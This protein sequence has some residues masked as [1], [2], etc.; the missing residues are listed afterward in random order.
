[1]QARHLTASLLLTAL[2]LAAQPEIHPDELALKPKVDEAIAAGVEALL[3]RQ[4]RDGSWSENNYPG[5]RTALVAYA[6]LKSGVSKDH[7]ALRRAFAFL[8]GVEPQ[9]TYS[10]ALM[11]LAYAA[12]RD[13]AYRDRI[14][15]LTG[16][17]V[18]WQLRQG[19]F[20]YGGGNNHNDMSN[21]QYA[22]LGLWAGS[23]AGVRVPADCWMEL[24]EGALRYQ[25]AP[26]M[27]DTRT[28][29]GTGAAKQLVAG[30]EY[31]PSKKTDL[32]AVLKDRKATG[33]M[34]TAGVSVLKICEI[35]LGRR[36]GRRD[37]KRIEIAMDMGLNWLDAHFS[38]R[39]PQQPNKGGG[40]LFYY[41]YG[42]ERVGALTRRETFGPHRWYL[43]GARLLLKR[44]KK[45]SWGRA[46][47]ESCFA[48]LFLRRATG[49][50]GPVTGGA[51]GK[52]THLFAAGGAKDDIRLRGAG[53]SPV[54]FY[55][56]GFGKE[57]L[58]EHS[59]QGLRILRV[60]YLEG[61]RK[62]AELAG[63]P[64]KPWA[65]DTFLHRCVA[66]SHGTHQ[67]VARVV[68]LKPDAANGDASQTITITSKPMKVKIRDVFEPWMKRIAEMQDDNLL[69]IGK[70]KAKVT[71][72]S[73][74]KTADNV[75]DGLDSTR[76]TAHPTDTN[77]TLT[78]ELTRPI[79]ARRII[80]T[81]ALGAQADLDRVGQIQAIELIRD[82]ARPIRIEMNP[83]PLDT[84][85]F[86]FKTARRLEKFSIRV[87][88]RSGKKDQPV[89]FAE[90]ALAS[91]ASR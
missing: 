90:I 69:R 32:G 40:R 60:E 11:I 84:T 51:G 17:I 23:Q 44:Q 27:A 71:A 79:R 15:T 38:V 41:L 54:M 58:S 63:N 29:K 28:K 55:L 35:G 59:A 57:L 77:P 25:E 83:N 46:T 88:Q 50:T 8:D 18:S 26:Y 68:A 34:T 87:V 91:S 81:Q 21:T 20:G 3:D 64:N 80:L 5:G 78:F 74:P 61:E 70:V 16:R 76:W 42:M 89:G 47:H 62:L 7:P 33:T 19:D 66:L 31:R 6:L 1:M 75:V 30:F 4:L 14:E 2:G 52:S 39:N 56:D 85:E 67:V 9:K 49:M 13:D 10:T 37:R 45:G 73:N 12:L 24:I 72:S 82:R 22:A 53:Q 48:L 36:L 86:E 65:K 43:E